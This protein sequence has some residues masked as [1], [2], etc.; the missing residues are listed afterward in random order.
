MRKKTPEPYSKNV[1]NNKGVMSFV[2]PISK[3]LVPYTKKSK[4]PRK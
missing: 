2:G 1:K 3:G 4:K